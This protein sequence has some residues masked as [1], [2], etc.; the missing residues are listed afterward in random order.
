MS[1]GTV[2][3]MAIAVNDLD[4]AISFHTKVLGFKLDSIRDTQGKM[5]G[6]RSAVLFSDSFSVVLLMSTSPNSQIARYIEKY[7]PG[8]Q[9]VAFSVKKIESVHG[10]LKE[11]G[12]GFST[13]ILKSSGL[14]QVFTQR[15]KN[16]GMMYEFIERD[17]NFN[18]EDEN[19]NRLFE[20]LESSDSF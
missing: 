19:V 1:C 14:K 17:G 8:V 4:E 5:S 20:Q 13:E 7:G 12:M 15:D 16:T 6:M 18:F 11:K 9:H 3:H 2:D 10:E